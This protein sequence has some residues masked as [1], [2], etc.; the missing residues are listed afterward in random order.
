MLAL[1]ATAPAEQKRSAILTAALQ[2]FSHYGYRRTAMEDIAQEAN[3][4]RA[5]LY[6]HFKNKEE[7]FRALARRLNEQALSAAQ[8]AALS[9][10]PIATRVERV[11]EAKLGTFF[12]IVHGSAHARELLDE[13][14][15]IGGDISAAFRQKHVGVLRRALAAAVRHEGLDLRS[16]GLT[17]QSAAELVLDCAKGLEGSPDLTPA[18]FRRRLRQMVA[19]L[20]GG[21]SREHSKPFAS[22]TRR[23]AA[24]RRPPA[25]RQKGR[26]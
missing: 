15:R 23:R 2:R 22:S 1:A 19:L 20:I 10:A 13:G 11:L 21:V 6:L 16:H 9:D 17:A 24:S 4:S 5:A 3:L 8:Q 25:Q 26:L 12:E 18:L 14:S 7:I